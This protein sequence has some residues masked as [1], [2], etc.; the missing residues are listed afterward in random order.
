[1]ENIIPI[2]EK[3]RTSMTNKIKLFH[4]E[5]T[6]YIIMVLPDGR[7]GRTTNSIGD[8]FLHLYDLVFPPCYSKRSGAEQ[9]GA[10]AKYSSP[11]AAIRAMKKH[12]KDVAYL[13]S[14]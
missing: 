3:P 2:E 6:E 7:I 14:L 5:D 8:K 1:M 13:G 12:G 4:R 10:W 9:S 11:Q